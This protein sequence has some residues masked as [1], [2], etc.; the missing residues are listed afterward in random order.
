M[1]PGDETPAQVALRPAAVI[2]AAHAALGAAGNLLS[3]IS[4]QAQ[5]GW[6]TGA[7]GRELLQ[8]ELGEIA[9]DL[10]QALSAVLDFM[11]ARDEDDNQL[12]GALERWL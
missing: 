11:P 2:A 3:L 4:G 8:T 10:A 9:Q 6:P 12:A 1:I 5:D 7:L